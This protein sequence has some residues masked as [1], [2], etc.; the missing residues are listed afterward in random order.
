MYS[1]YPN[2][3]SWYCKNLRFGALLIPQ[4]W[5][6]RIVV[7]IS[8]LRLKSLLEGCER[9]Q[10]HMGLIAYHVPG[11]HI[12]GS[13]MAKAQGTCS[14]SF[15]NS[16]LLSTIYFRSAMPTLFLHLMATSFLILQSIYFITNLQ[17]TDGWCIWN[18]SV[19]L[20]QCVCII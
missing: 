15:L 3:T 16:S 11:I 10:V 20:N 1:P 6:S 9:K 18:E 2:N 5:Q 4:I 17:V 13:Q 14:F 12:Y 8:L 7:H 19:H